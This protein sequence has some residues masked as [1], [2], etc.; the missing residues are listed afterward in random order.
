MIKL[1]DIMDKYGEYTIDEEKLKE[2]SR[3]TKT[4]FNL[5]T[6]DNYYYLAG[7]GGLARDTWDNVKTD[8]KRLEIGSV[9]LTEESAAFEAERRKIEIEMLKCGGMRDL[10]LLGNSNVQK[11]YIYYDHFSDKLHI[12]SLYTT[13]YFGSIYFKTVQDCQNAIDKIGEDKIRKYIFN[14]KEK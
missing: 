13:H 11:Y 2:I 9:F 14:V 10:M 8:H 6:G 4:I 7:D 3:E 12:G 5:K 1:K